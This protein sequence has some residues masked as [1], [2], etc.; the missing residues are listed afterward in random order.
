M[1]WGLAIGFLKSAIG[2]VFDFLNK[3]VDANARIHLSDN[4]TLQRVG[5]TV[6]DGAS[7][8]DE[9]NEKLREKEGPFSPMVV[10]SILGFL[11]PFAWHTW[12]VCLDSSRWLPSYDFLFGFIPY[13]AVSV[14]I[15]GSWR[16]AALPGLFETTEHAVIQSLFIG[17]ST[18]AAGFA[19][20]KAARR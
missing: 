17:A 2:P 1:L 7:K 15:V 6:I 3:R 14:H 10:C 13:P 5:S 12:Q 19:L 16:V 11:A 9:L 20:I 8:A 4:E 18:A